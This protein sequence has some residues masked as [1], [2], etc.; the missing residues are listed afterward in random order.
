ML[1]ESVAMATPR[2]FCRP[3]PPS[4]NGTCLRSRFLLDYSIGLRIRKIV[5]KYSR[6][7]SANRLEFDSFAELHH[8]ID[9]FVASAFALFFKS[10]FCIFFLDIFDFFLA[11][12]IEFFAPKI[13][14]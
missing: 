3:R 1:Q 11:K 5:C 2:E 9:I 7:L 12:F 10:I 8:L 14:F 13:M 6:S 4:F